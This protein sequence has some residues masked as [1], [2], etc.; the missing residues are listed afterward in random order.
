MEFEWDPRKA[1]VNLSTHGIDFARV[2]DIFL[3]RVAVVRSDRTP[4]ARWKAIGELNGVEITVIFTWRGDRRRII[5]ARRA[6]ANERRAYR[7]V[8]SHGP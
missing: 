5:S 2:M 6:R 3:D 1:E 8:F 4:E 7:E